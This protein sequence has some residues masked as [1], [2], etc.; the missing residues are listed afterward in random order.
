[1]E[2]SG[3]SADQLFISVSSLPSDQTSD[4]LAEYQRLLEL[5]RLSPGHAASQMQALAAAKTFVEGLKR[6]GRSLSRQKLIEALEGM[7][8]FRTGLTPPITF[9]PNRRVG[10]AGA[11]IVTVDKKEQKLVPVS[12]WIEAD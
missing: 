6:V 1:M 10:S 9:T 2:A 4:A 7:Y 3:N 11:Y 8:Q 5:Y 12:K